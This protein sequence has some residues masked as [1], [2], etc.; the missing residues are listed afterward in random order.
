MIVH[1]I[2][3]VRISIKHFGYLEWCDQ[4]TIYETRYT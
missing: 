2:V 3:K 4:F 1:I